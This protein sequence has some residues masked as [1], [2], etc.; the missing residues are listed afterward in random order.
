MTT[1]LVLTD[2]HS[3]YVKTSV[4]S[5]SGSKFF[6]LNIVWKRCCICLRLTYFTMS[7]IN[8]AKSPNQQD[9]LPLNIVSKSGVFNALASDG[10][11]K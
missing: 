11:S 9:Y 4:Y 7:Q 8:K 1:E 10:D 2:A 5:F 6:Y 3:V